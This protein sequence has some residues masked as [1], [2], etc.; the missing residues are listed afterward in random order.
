[1][2]PIG[3]PPPAIFRANLEFRGTNAP[4]SV[5]YIAAG[6][7][8]VPSIEQVHELEF[9]LELSKVLFLWAI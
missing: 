9:G 6:S 2:V 7:E 4:G 3:L 5:L 1:M 8:T